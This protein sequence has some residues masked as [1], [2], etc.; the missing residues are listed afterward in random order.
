MY[1]KGFNHEGMFFELGDFNHQ[2]TTGPAQIAA[3]MVTP[4]RR[5]QGCLDDAGC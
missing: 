5:L 1:M 4:R 2:S 3:L